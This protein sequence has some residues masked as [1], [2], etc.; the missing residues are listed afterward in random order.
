M[1]TLSVIETKHSEVYGLRCSPGGFGGGDGQRSR[2]VAQRTLD[3]TE[4]RQG[5]TQFFCH[6]CARTFHQSWP[7]LSRR[8]GGVGSTNRA[9]TQSEPAQRWLYVTCGIMY[10]DDVCRSKRAETVVRIGRKF[11]ACSV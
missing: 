9:L 1:H 7:S 4:K 5:R 3:R 2:I 6:R 8:N 11:L 10:F